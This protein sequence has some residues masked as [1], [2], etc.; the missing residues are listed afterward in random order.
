M[1]KD[2]MPFQQNNPINITTV[3]SYDIFIPP[4]PRSAR[5]PAIIVFHGGGQD[6]RTIEAR[7]GIDPANPPVPPLVAEYMLVFPETDPTL[8]DEWVHYKKGDSKFPEHDLLFVDTLVNE[9]TNVAYATGDP[10]IPT[11]S[12]DPTLLYAAGFSSGAGMV[13]QIANSSRVASFQGFAVVGKG[14]DPEKAIHFRQQLGGAAPPPIPLIYIMGTADPGFRSPTTLAEV[15]I[16][17]TYPFYSVKEMIERN[18]IPAGPAQTSLTPGS[19][20]VT[21]VVTQL[22][23]GGTEAF[24][25]VTVING[26]HNWPTPTTRGNPPVANHYDAT[27]AIVQFW[28]NFASLPP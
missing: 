6:I 23:T 10:N 1:R 27:E 11:V 2:T 19:T 4:T 9:I 7:W 18:V 14:L 28:R 3:R 25:Y 22:W 26:G 12:A 21:E 17:S 20:N 13:W 16:P 8:T 15:P 24:C 5:L